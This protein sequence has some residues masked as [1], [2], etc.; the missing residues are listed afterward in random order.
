MEKGAFHDKLLGISQQITVL[1]KRSSKGDVEARDELYPLIYND[2]K[3]RAA[4]LLRAERRDHSLQPTALLHEA[5]VRLAGV[6][7]IDWQSRGHFF[8]VASRIMRQLLISHARS[9]NAEK[10]GGTMARVDLETIGEPWKSPEPMLIALD[11]ALE[12]LK[13]ESPRAY[14]LVEM[15]FFGGLSFEEAAQALEVSS[16]TLKRD[17]EAAK[18]WLARSVQ[19]SE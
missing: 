18:L 6:E 1:L 8:A 12:R 17:W 14:A 2:L 13:E 7:R 19:K 15:K 3:A 10:R 4:G 11:D 9:R 5:F 16:R